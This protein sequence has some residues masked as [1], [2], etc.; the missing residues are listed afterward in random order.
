[1]PEQNKSMADGL[2]DTA[3]SAARDTLTLGK[4]AANL[5][6]GNIAG[7][8]KEVAK[9]PKAVLHAIVFVLL[10]AV[11]CIL[12]PVFIILAILG[13]I[14]SI[15]SVIT[16]LF[17]GEE[18]SIESNYE[19]YQ[20]KLESI[21]KKAY[22]RCRNQAESSYNQL[23]DAVYDAWERLE[24]DGADRVELSFSRSYSGMFGDDVSDDSDDDQVVISQSIM[25]MLE[26]YN[27][28]NASLD[29][30]VSVDHD[31][32]YFGNITEDDNWDEYDQDSL[33]EDYTEEK[34]TP[35]LKG[36]RKL[37]K[38]NKD[39]LFEAE[40]ATAEELSPEAFSFSDDIAINNRTNFIATVKDKGI[41]EESVGDMESEYVQKYSLDVVTLIQYTGEQE[42]K[43]NVFQLSDEDYQNA[44][45]MAEALSMVIGNGG[46]GSMTEAEIQTILA[47]LRAQGISEERV[48]LV[49]AALKGV[50]RFQYSQPL[51][52]LAGTGPDD[53][54]VGKDLDCSSFV[55]YCYWSAGFEN[56]CNT[57]ADYAGSAY[58]Y[59][60]DRS[61]KLPGDIFWHQN[62]RGERHVVI[63]G[64]NI[65]G[66][67]IYI[68]CTSPGSVL[69]YG[70][71]YY[72]NIDTYQYVY[73]YNGFD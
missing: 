7:A 20:D 58:F 19:E 55:R 17:A 69:T 21:Y 2:K 16:Q 60:I 62:A 63:Y 35:T 43:D 24:V 4:A 22:R 46:F 68:E 25:R 9:N 61:E 65:G 72:G 5:V 59:Q 50:G 44:L 64:G 37:I 23:Q 71:C 18:W 14:M 11:V 36:L 38:E 27:L 34:N 3:R 52:S 32:S 33:T 41:E 26:M 40:T 29:D 48:A 6:A 45:G 51:R 39:S 67:D 54:T 53:F 66:E 13:S 12:L 30:T 1:M 31:N 73:R 57:T 47:E 42:F 8:A 49:E 10:A 70:D 15:P 56:D 28:W